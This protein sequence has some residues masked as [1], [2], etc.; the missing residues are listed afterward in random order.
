VWPAAP[1]TIGEAFRQGASVE[2]QLR[3]ASAPTITGDSAVVLCQRSVV[4]SFPNKKLDPVVDRVTVRLRRSG[5]GW[6]IDSIQ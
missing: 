3:P 2:L 6:A 4:T 1:K 5:S